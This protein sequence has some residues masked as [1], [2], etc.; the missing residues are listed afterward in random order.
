MN[1]MKKVSV[2]ISCILAS[3]L[4]T[5]CTRQKPS[6]I[7]VDLASNGIEVPKDLW[8]IFY[9]EINRAGDGGLWPEMIYNMGFEEKVLPST[10]TIENGLIV[11]PAK[12]CY[13]IDR[14]NNYRFYHF[15]PENK[16]EGWK[17][18]NKGTSKSAMEVVSD[19]PL[20]KENPHSLLLRIDAVD[21][22]VN[23]IN[24]GFKGIS[25]VNGEKYNLQFYLRTDKSY[26]GKVVASLVGKTEN[27]IYSQEFD[28]NNSGVWI[29][30]KSE[31]ASN[32]T[33]NAVKLVLQ[34]SS[35][36]KVW[37]D[38][39]SLLPQ[40]TFKGHGLRQ[41]IA[42]TL[43]DMN[44]SF[45]RWPG[46]CIVE[47]MTMENRV[48][49]KETIGDRMSRKGQFDLWGYH[50]TG[51]FGYHD[52]LQFCEDIGASGM[53]VVN[54]GLSCSYRNGDYY[55]MN[56]MKGIIQDILDGI[57]YAIGDVSTKWGAERARNGHPAPFQL[58]YVEIGNENY[59]PKYNERYNI[60]YD[61]CKEKFP[62]II[63]INDNSL[64]GSNMPDYKADKIEMLDLHYYVA[65]ET[66]FNTVNLYD[67]VSR[68]NFKIY[69]GEYA[70]NSN[71]GSGTLEGALAEA[72]FMFG[73]EQNSDLVKI[74]SYAPLLENVN[75]QHWPTNLIRFKNDSVFGRSSYYVQK[76]FNEN[77][78]DVTLQ[79]TL[80]LVR[81]EE[82]ISGKVGFAAIANSDNSAI[83]FKDFSV[84]EGSVVKYASEFPTDTA[85]WKITGSWS[86]A[87][88]A[89]STGDLKDL[90][91]LSPAGLYV[92]GNPKGNE[93]SV[94]LSS[95]GSLILNNLV[96]NN[97]TISVNIMTDSVFNGFNIRFGVVDDKNYFTLTISNPRMR[98]FFT[99]IS[100]SGNQNQPAKYVASIE[101]VVNGTTLR[102]GTIG[103]SFDF[104]MGS[105]HNIK[106]SINGRMIACAVDDNNLG[107]I[108]YR[109]LRKQH[110]V[111]GYDN[112]DGEVIVKVVNGEDTPF[113]SEINLN[114]A[115]KVDPIGQIIT[116]SSV[117]DKD[118]NSFAEP[119]KVTPVVSEYKGFSN[120]FK[121]EFKPNSFT[122]LRIK[123]SR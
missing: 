27:T 116:L 56:E 66:F 38:Y 71:V 11:P 36:G 46:G 7:T 30:Y 102:L 111:A 91:Y 64:N 89:I 103:S 120:S 22:S 112:A 26:N 49:W 119:K 43:A 61:A 84:T 6:I 94:R 82:E 78:P 58:K 108:E 47:G 42:Q 2:L 48:Q 10:C 104:N 37:I 75:W 69:I 90:S 70:V 93:V 76:M 39:V 33:D 18:E 110:A 63:Y 15:D 109:S 74:A 19:N 99:P 97:C 12:P 45:I 13:A 107:E 80:D 23:L 4:I 53:W 88:N 17:L 105:W 67:T 115:K 55:E 9:E 35:T 77:M 101:H 86:V 62:Q 32:V 21:G 24:E 41:D 100:L 51:N 122:I 68:S 98:R 52:F 34:F 57:E 31:I 44:P 106:V 65:P 3:L 96:F 8:G 5:G 16:T 25:L 81:P 1:I 14:V 83:K 118:D 95:G 121:M 79:A 20:N 72:S 87:E 28:V 40:T 54:A 114:N 117:S 73:I 60:I 59:G 123:A 113:N 50:N 85:K 92:Q 29:N